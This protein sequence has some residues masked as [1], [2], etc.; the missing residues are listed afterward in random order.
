[1]SQNVF[2]NTVTEYLE[3]L[4]QQVQSRL[5]RSP[6]TCLAIY[7]LL[8][9]M[10]KFFIMS[11]IFQ[12][13][14][15]SL[16]DLDRWVKPD[17]KFQL[18][19]AIKSMKLLHIMMEGQSEQ[20]LMTRLNPIFKES[21]KNAL[22]GGEVNN[23]FGN[24]VEDGDEAVTMSMLDSYAADKWETILHF[25]VGTP[26]TKSPGRNVLNL[27]QHSNLMEVDE[28]G[29]LKITNVGFQ[30][31]LQEPNA[32]IWT[33][34]LQYLKMAETLQM[35]PVDVLNLVFMVGALELG[36]AYSVIG[37]SETQRAMLQ[38]LRDYGL[39]FQK[40]SNLNKFYPTKLATLLTSDV[41]SIKSASSAVDSMLKKTSDAAD[42]AVNANGIGE[43]DHQDGTGQN[44][45]DG[46]LIIE[47]N[48]KLY[49]YSNSPLQIAIL[50]LFVHLKS[51]FQNMVTGQVT[52][53]SIRRALHNGITADQIIAYL[54]THAHPQMRR[55][56][57]ETLEKKLELDPNTKESLQVLPPT[58]V[59]QIKLW[60][61]ELD[62]IISY[63]GY[64]FRDFDNF[65]EYQ[66]M[67]QYARDI[68]VLLWS[69]DK[70]RMFFVSK[71]GNAQVI[72]YHKRNFKKKQ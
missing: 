64:L 8:P 44:I 40:Q 58:V 34:L 41:V 39:V 60:Q 66:S 22:T 28:D 51:R 19:D 32:Q 49:S 55:L 17:A 2:K 50:S 20:P 72:D 46:A 7:R 24:L 15:V 18:H 35:D 43:D 3:G 23:S 29:A 52:R 68:G 30:F 63:D 69:D 54:E 70:K 4:P 48:F 16:R 36:N 9:P 62:R 65:Q 57:E 14:E 61:L 11:M 26:L 47:T 38:D 25:M 56:A 12:D 42:K 37:L 59:D 33:L 5:Y 6:A 1:M 27:L 53:E 67:T 10:A 71:D 21:F 45:P 13:E 31:L